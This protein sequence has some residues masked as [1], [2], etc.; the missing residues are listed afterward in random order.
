MLT[1]FSDWLEELPDDAPP[2]EKATV[3]NCDLYTLLS[4]FSALRQ[5]IKFQNR[6]QNR[7]TVNLSDMQAGYEKSLALFEKSVRG[8]DTLSRDIRQDAEKKSILPFLE[9]RDALVRGK[10]ACMGVIGRSRWYRPAPKGTESIAEGYEMATR[11]FDR[12]LSNVGIMPIE[13]VGRPFDPKQMK[14]V[15]KQSDPEVAAGIVLAEETGGFIRNNEVV[16][17]A[18]VI[19]NDLVIE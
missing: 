6:E 14:A 18:E 12:A 19:V 4:E 17:T 16:R 5:E 13:A 15:G 11:R 8:I 2:T 9:I 7:T 10:A 3:E 1:D